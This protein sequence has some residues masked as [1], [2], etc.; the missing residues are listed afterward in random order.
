MEIGYSQTELS[1]VRKKTTSFSYIV[2]VAVGVA[3][4][5]TPSFLPISGAGEYAFL[6]Q[7][8][9]FSSMRMV[10]LDRAGLPL[11]IISFQKGAESLELSETDSML[12][13]EEC[14]YIL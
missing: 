9:R 6:C 7:S 2:A 4:V 3:P 1:S 14:Q 8:K 11:S 10:C 13:L 5:L 12:S